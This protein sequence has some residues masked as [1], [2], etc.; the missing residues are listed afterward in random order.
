[1]CPADHGIALYLGHSEGC[2]VSG[3]DDQTSC[4]KAILEGSDE[5][6]WLYAEGIIWRRRE[7]YGEVA[8]GAVEDHLADV[9]VL[10]EEVA[11]VQF[12]F[13]QYL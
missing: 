13:V 1:M 9:H 4:A 6:F 5:G 2:G 10:F 11:E 8:S 3:S 12:S 7:C